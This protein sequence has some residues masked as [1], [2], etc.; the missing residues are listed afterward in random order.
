MSQ[1]TSTMVDVEKASAPFVGQWLRLV[2]TTNWVK[3]R[4]IHEWRRA[5]ITSGA[6]STQYSDEAWSNAVGG[7]TSQHVGRLRRVHERFG[8]VHVHYDGLFWSHFQAAIDWDDAEM[9]LEGAVQ[10][11]WS[12][13]AMR[14]KRAET[15]NAISLPPSADEDDG[16]DD[17]DEDPMDSETDGAFPPDHRS[18]D[19]PDFSD[20]FGPAGPDF[21]D[22]DDNLDANFGPDD[23]DPDPP[24]V[25]VTDPDLIRPFE[26]L[27]ALPDDLADAYEALKLAILR[28]KGDHWQQVSRDDVLASLDALKLLIVAPSPVPT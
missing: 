22:D 11:R 19:D 14:D 5:M 16:E 9:W 2:S 8:E 15:L 13:Q 24:D 1:E 27:A 3:G 28:H 7:V 4:I 21:G 17:I 25:D 6:P 26:N 18:F 23:G 10:N 20:E 12:V